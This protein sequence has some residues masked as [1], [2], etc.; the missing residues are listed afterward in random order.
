MG[1]GCVR[2]VIGCGEVGYGDVCSSDGVVDDALK[3][4][5]AKVEED[6]GKEAAFTLAGGGSSADAGAGFRSIP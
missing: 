3:V 5:N 2:V 1:L 6:C 4:G